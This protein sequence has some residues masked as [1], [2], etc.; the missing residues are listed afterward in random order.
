MICR[1]RGTLE[2]VDGML[3]VLALDGGLWREVLLPA[4]LAASWR[5]RIGQVVTLNT[6]E[7]LE[8]HGQ[9]TSFVPR[10]VGF[11]TPAERRFFEVFTTV[12]GLGSRRAL[13]AMEADPAAIAEAIVRRD[14][15]ALQELPEIGKR[16]SETIV[17]ELSG[18][19]EPLLAGLG[20]TPGIAEPKPAARPA[21]SGAEEAV[22]AL[23]ALGQT[24][25][26][27]ERGVAAAASLVGED[28]DT[29]TL[30]SAAFGAAGETAARPG[31]A[32]GR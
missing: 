5:E 10:L 1:I 3:A 32:R 8:G 30:V 23:M 25:A 31:R 6:L 16:L 18:K 11:R 27:A 28:A 4:Y 29:D 13:R 19:I 21:T 7:Y 15:R 26:E 12:K 9:G 14:A 24:R 2:T 22:L 17:A 20:W